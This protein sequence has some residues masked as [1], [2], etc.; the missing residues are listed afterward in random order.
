[1]SA[2]R[3]QGPARRKLRAI[4]TGAR[5]RARRRD[6]QRH[7]R[8]HRHDLQG[9]RRH[10]HAART[11]TPT[12]RDQR[13]AVVTDSTSGNADHPGVAARRRSAL[14]G[15]RRRPPARCSTSPAADRRSSSTATASRSAPRARP[16]FGFGIDPT[17]T[18]FNPFRSTEGRWARG[19]D[20]VVIDEGTAAGQHFARRRHDR[21]RRPT[22]RP[23]AFP[24]SAIVE[25]R[26][27]R[28]LG[29]ATIAVFDVPTAQQLL[30]KRRLDTISVAAGPGVSAAQLVAGSAAILPADAQVQT[31]A[32]QAQ[33]DART[34]R[35]SSRFIRC[36]LL[37]FAAIALFVGAFVI[38]NTLSITVAQRTREFATLRTLGASRRQVM[39]SVLLE[40]LGVG[41]ARRSSGSSP[42]SAS[43]RA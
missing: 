25:V 14:P 11:R 23:A 2:R 26:R 31:G 35:R 9:L 6:G 19:P 39:R 34:A 12:R 27:R 30:D 8:P 18:R 40:A 24:I 38:F 17:Q 32:E 7:V 16:N 15:R 10:L 13:Q 1:M 21:R 37:A 20:Q 41:L 5:D 22:A 43:P 28:S 42:A 36:F 29:G 4:L 33:A 3:A